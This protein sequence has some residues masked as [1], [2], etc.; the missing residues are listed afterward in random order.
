MKLKIN[1]WYPHILIAFDQATQSSGYSVWDKDTKNLLDYG[2]LKVTGANSTKRINKIKHEIM[3]L[4]NDLTAENIEVSFAFEDIQYQSD[5]ENEHS[6]G[7]SF[8]KS[9]NY[10]MNNVKTFKSLAWLQGVLFDMCQELNISYEVI[11]SSTWKSFCKIKGQSRN[12]QKQNSIDFARTTFGVEV[13]SDEADAI[14][15][16]WTILHK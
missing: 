8:G 1:S 4:Y 13:S 15:L 5:K 6:G 11:F 2:L 14:C 12:I 10:A 3:E 16:G 7:I 9:I